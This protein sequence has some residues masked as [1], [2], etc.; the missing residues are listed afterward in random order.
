M[1][2]EDGILVKGAYVVINGVK[3]EVHMPEYSGNTPAT[4]ENLNKAQEDV[5]KGE[6]LY[7]SNLGASSGTI[8][9]SSSI[10]TVKKIGITFEEENGVEGYREIENPVRENS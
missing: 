6:T 1:K 7:E 2:F 9:L 3:Y 8:I 5:I 4:A 10:S